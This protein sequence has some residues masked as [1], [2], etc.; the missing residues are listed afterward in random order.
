MSLTILFQKSKSLIIY[1]EDKELNFGEVEELSLLFINT[2][3]NNQKRILN[4]QLDSI[5]LTFSFEVPFDMITLFF[6]H[7]ADDVIIIGVKNYDDTDIE[8]L[9]IPQTSF[10]KALVDG[11]VNFYEQLKSEGIF[12]KYIIDNYPTRHKKGEWKDNYIEVLQLFYNNYY[13]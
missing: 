6:H 5:A 1:Y 9:L 7:F 10:Y 11:L 2:L 3:F 12:E 8:E 4:E 13:T